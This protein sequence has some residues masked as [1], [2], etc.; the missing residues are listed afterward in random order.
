MG[1][2]GPDAEPS[3]VL[4]DHDQVITFLEDH[5][6]RYILGFDMAVFA[7]GT[8]IFN[9]VSPHPRGRLGIS[10]YLTRSVT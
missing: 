9:E 4:V 8:A 2:R 3:A 7:S 5:G 6:Q 10:D 1:E